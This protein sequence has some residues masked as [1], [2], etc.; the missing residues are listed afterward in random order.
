M[1]K[2]LKSVVC[3][4]LCWWMPRVAWAEETPSCER[5]TR[6]NLVSCAL[7]ASL[8]V[9]SEQKSEE[10]LRGRRTA[11]GSVLPSNP[12]LALSAARREAKG[13]EPTATNWYATLSQELEIAGQRGA[14]V[15]AADLELSAQSK[16]TLLRKRETA[17]GAWRS[18]FDAIAARE[19]QVLMEDL[20]R[21]SERMAT[22]S[23]ARAEKGLSAPLE[24]DLAEAVSFR[25]LQR[26]T[27]ADRAVLTA[28]ANLAFLLGRDG[29]QAQP[30][31]G[32]LLPLAGIPDGGDGKDRRLEVAIAEDQQKANAARASAYRRSRVPNPTLSVFAQNDGYNER[33]YGLGLSFPIPLPSPVGRTFAGEIAES[34][35]LAQRAELD[36]QRAVRDVKLDRANAY[37]S[38]RAHK[39]LVENLTTERVK[40]AKGSL[41]DL[42]TEIESGRLAVRDAL[43]AQQTLIE[44]LE[45]DITERRA[46]CFASVQVAEA[47][48]LSLEE[49]SR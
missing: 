39:Q 19:L 17:A 10:A 31:D 30:V 6:A 4:A 49:G 42:S 15:D 29:T 46:L 18:Y 8:T 28:D 11:V 34:E 14:R 24:A 22:V 23:R 1:S 7:S 43:L 2:R 41:R 25:A 32:A 44:L 20:F 37:A 3:V 9:R 12:V 27:E 16:T 26:K 35:A 13:T 38:Y 47:L 40:R 33:V 5:V 48:G 45:A 36:R 21:A